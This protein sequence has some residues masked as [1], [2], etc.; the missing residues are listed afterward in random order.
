MNANT[1]Q[2]WYDFPEM[3]TMD[4]RTFIQTLTF[5]DQAGTVQPSSFQRSPTW[6][7]NVT[8]IDP[9]MIVTPF[10]TAV[11][12]ITVQNAQDYESQQIANRW[13]SS[14]AMTAT[15][16]KLPRSVEKIMFLKAG[17]AFLN[18]LYL[19]WTVGVTSTDIQFSLNMNSVTSGDFTNSASGTI[20]VF[21]FKS[22]TYGGT[23]R[24]LNVTILRPGRYDVAIRIIDNSGNSSMY[25]MFWIV[26]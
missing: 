7:Q 14:H 5:Q 21:A 2:S 24:S 8:W 23:A 15:S 19:D 12:T 9:P 3:E 13:N 20:P 16:T 18:T 26:L 4:P 25:E 6:L 22:A 1:P 11:P 17:A 10:A